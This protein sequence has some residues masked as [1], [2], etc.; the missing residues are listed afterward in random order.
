MVGRELGLPAMASLR[1]IHNIKG[2]H[3]LSA[4]LM[5]G[6]VIKSGLAD[7]FRPVTD[8]AGNIDADEKHATFETLRKG[9][10]NRL[11]RFT[12]TIE[13]ATTAGLVKKDSGWEKNPKSMLI[14][15]A[16]AG[17]ARLIYP[18]LMA[19]LYTPE[20]LEE[21]RNAA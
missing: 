16:E 6:L 2:Q 8:D 18:E 1:G 4:A 19:G 7:F 21:V 3:A 17:L 13:E 5:A 20:E 10:D 12:Y 14:A 9:P 15:R 11:T